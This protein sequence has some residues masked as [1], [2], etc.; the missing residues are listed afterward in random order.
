[1]AFTPRFQKIIDECV[2]RNEE[3]KSVEATRAFF[4]EQCIAIGQKERINNLYRIRPKRALLGDRSRM[5]FFRMNDIQDTFWTNKTNRDCILKMRQGGVTTLSC[6]IAL[7]FSIWDQGAQSVI[8][9]HARDNVKKIFRITKSAFRSFQKDWQDLCPVTEVVDN[10]TELKINE[11]GS[12]LMVSTETKGLTLDFLHISE[13]AFIEDARISESVESVP[14]SAW[15]IMETTPDV[16]AGLFYEL[17]DS[18][19]RGDIAGKVQGTY[20]NHF[21][22]W[23]FHYPEEEDLPMLKPSETFYLTDKE[24]VVETKIRDQKTVDDIAP[25]ILWRRIKIAECGGDEGEFA[26]KYP[27][28]PMTCFLSGSRSVFPAGILASL[29]RQETN[30]RWMG[31]LNLEVSP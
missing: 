18:G 5:Q 4:R 31:D 3:R 15:V 27:E 2:K 13:A 28:D 1:M 29:F 8:M 14:L 26:R 19:E 20:K 6:L 24:K 25:Y 22:P 11:T 12:H 10:V 16:A 23:W 17:W 30:P 9:A 7:D 21:F